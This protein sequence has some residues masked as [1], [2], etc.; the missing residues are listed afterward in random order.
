MNILSLRLLSTVLLLLA[1]LPT[2][3]VNYGVSPA[4]DGALVVLVT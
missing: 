3:S 4:E 2:H 1:L